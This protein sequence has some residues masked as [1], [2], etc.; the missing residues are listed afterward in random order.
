MPG[1]VFLMLRI[2]IDTLSQM[3]N[4]YIAVE[5]F[6]VKSPQKKIENKFKIRA[7][8]VQKRQKYALI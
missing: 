7:A 6:T 1:D 4:V 3:L 8:M 5:Q 2:R